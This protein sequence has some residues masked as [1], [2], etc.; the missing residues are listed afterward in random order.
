MANVRII[1]QTEITSLQGNEFLVTDSATAGTKKITPENLVKAAG[2][3]SG[4]TNEIKTALLDCF[5]HVAWIDDDGQDYYD[6]L[7]AALNPPQGLSSISAV[8]TQSGTVYDTDSLNSLK[9]DLVVTAHYD[10]TTTATVTTYTLSGTLTVGT[11]TIT[12]SYGGKTT[13]FSVTVTAAPDTPLY[14]W[15]F[16]TSLTDTVEGETAVL[17]S[18]ASQTSNGIEFSSANQAAYIKLISTAA[19]DMSDK[20]VEIDIPT[21]QMTSGLSSCHT[22]LFSIATNP[23]VTN[24]GASNFI[25]RYNTSTGWDL[26]TGTAWAAD[27]LDNTTYGINF[28]AGK[29]LKLYIDSSGYVTV[30][31]ATIGSDSYTQIKTFSTPIGSTYL[32]GYPMIGGKSGDNMVGAVISAVRIYDGQV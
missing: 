25:W 4:L 22:R 32:T 23:P 15:D 16:K 8:Y 21:C 2:A 14:D 11:S 19:V 30:S 1:D 20:T 3:G 13:T 12:V 27:K 9:S 6:A 5:E 26:Y 29:T 31:Y 18:Y 10:D 28:F 24:S 7:E 17:G